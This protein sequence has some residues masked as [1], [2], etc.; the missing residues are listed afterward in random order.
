MDNTVKISMLLQLYEKLLTEK[1]REL[2]EDYYNNDLS[3]SEIAENQGIT[4]QAVRDNLKKGENNLLEYEKK[5]KLMKKFEMQKKELQ[6]ILNEITEIEVSKEV[7]Q[8]LESL[9][10]KILS[11]ENKLI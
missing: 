7:K 8:K 10:K 1:Q 9:K 2:L 11:F 3:L 6:E 5:L 4:R